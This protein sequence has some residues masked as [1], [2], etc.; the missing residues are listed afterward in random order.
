MATPAEIAA[1]RL[2]IAV[3]AA[4]LGTT[5]PNP[6]VG[7]VVIGADGQIVG[8]GFHERK[9]E[10]HAEAQAL[11][12]AGDLANGATAI[13]TLEPC[14]HQGRTPP[15]RQV[16]ID[17]GVR[18]VVIAIIDPTSRGEGGVVELRRAGVDVETGVLAG[19]ARTVLGDWLAGLQNRRP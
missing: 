6:P 5:S 7:C 18:R 13:V 8:E 16:L 3:S 9:G 17:A 15:C 1:M 11:A 10:P 19:E 4:G 12:A 2:A 14:N